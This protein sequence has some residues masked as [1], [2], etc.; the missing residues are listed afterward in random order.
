MTKI[1]LNPNSSN[2]SN[3]KAMFEGPATTNK[4]KVF[5]KDIN[6]VTNTT[7][8]EAKLPSPK[9]TGPEGKK[10]PPAVPKKTPKTKEKYNELKQQHE[11]NLLSKSVAPQVVELQATPEQKKPPVPPKPERL[12]KPPVPR[13]PTGLL[14]KSGLSKSPASSIKPGN[15]EE[16]AKI[17][18]NDRDAKLKKILQ[19]ISARK[20]QE[21]FRKHVERVKKDTPNGYGIV[22]SE[23]YNGTKPEHKG[24]IYYFQINDQ[25]ILCAMYSPTQAPDVSMEGSSKY[26]DRIDKNF[27]R[28]INLSDRFRKNINENGDLKDTSVIPGIAVDSHTMIARFGGDNLV[29]YLK[30]NNPPL[31]LSCFEKAAVDLNLLHSR[32]SFLADIKPQNLTFDGKNVNFI[33]VDDRIIMA[34]EEEAMNLH[35]RRTIGYIHSELRKYVALDINDIEYLVNDDEIWFNL[36][37]S[38]YKIADEYALLVSMMESTMEPNRSNSSAMTDIKNRGYSRMNDTEKQ[39]IIDWIENNVKTQ[40]RQNIKEILTNP[41]QYIRKYIKDGDIDITVI[42]KLSEMLDF[43]K[44]S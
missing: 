8:P 16:Q 24:R 41:Y 28:L 1:N 18:E 43:S 14:K 2:F 21:Y 31:N 35:D 30:K 4:P 40:H 6:S 34:D 11:A 39:P 33:D 44:K 13:K 22:S 19:N 12:T 25:G 15:S 17:D 42:P 29:D 5:K 37:P 38:L 10:S 20:I 9:A 26:V 36:I 7:Q 23:P 32:G 3:I 27:V